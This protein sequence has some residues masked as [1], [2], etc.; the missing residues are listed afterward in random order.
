MKKIL[1]VATTPLGY[2]GI[3]KVIKQ[4]CLYTNYSNLKMELLVSEGASESYINEVKEKVN[5]HYSPSRKNEII[6]YFFYLY[7]LCYREKYDIIHVHGNSATMCIDIFA[8]WIAKVPNRI[9]HSHNS[10]TKH[11][12]FHRILKPFLNLFVNNP[13]ACSEVAGKWVFYRGFSIIKN[14][15]E[16]DKYKFNEDSRRKI[17][18]QYGLENTFVIGHIGRFN[19]QKNHE[20]LINVFNLVL[21]ENRKF[22]LFLIGEGELL[23]E[24]KTQVNLLGIRSSV[25]FIGNVDNIPDYLCAMDLFLLPSRFEGLPLVCIEAQTSGLPCI[26]STAVSKETK[27]LDHFHFV[28]LNLNI[29][30]KF[31]NTSKMNL[32]RQRD[33]FK[34]KDRKFDI[35]DMIKSAIEV[36][37]KY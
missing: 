17:R 31:I 30:M 16:I 25:A 1:L 36:W 21:K 2:D 28:D 19:Y 8:A 9:A 32:F 4:L 12:V 33:F 24:I 29:W 5:I 14:G 22:K 35:N 6:N 26:V 23:E 3:S 20:F 18:K 34:V 15:I 13:V 10:S 37:N 11:I 7:K 27:I